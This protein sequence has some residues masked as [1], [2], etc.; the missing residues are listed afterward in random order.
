MGIQEQKGR[1]AKGYD[2][3][4]VVFNADIQIQQVFIN[5]QQY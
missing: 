5:G 3:D 1:I 2:A 4:I